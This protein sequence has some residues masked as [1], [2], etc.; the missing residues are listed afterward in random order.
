MDLF[1][2]HVSDLQE[3][4]TVGAT[5]ITGTLKYVNDYTGFSSKVEEQSG[6][7]LTIHADSTDADSITVELVGGTKG[8]V[9]LDEDGTI[10]IRI[11]NPATQSVRVVATKGTDSITKNYTLDV[12]LEP[13]ADG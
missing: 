7:Y 13:E 11:T 10:V 1:G 12:T 9:T 4:V 8:P 3:N 5:K 2:K 6:N